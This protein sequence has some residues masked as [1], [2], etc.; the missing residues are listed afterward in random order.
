MT[1][2]PGNKFG[3]RREKPCRDALLMVL[4]EA[5]EDMPE[6]R[7]IMQQVKKLALGGERWAA[8]EIWDRLDGKVPTE[9]K[10]ELGPLESMSDEQL[11][12]TFDALNAYLSTAG[13]ET[14]QPGDAEATRH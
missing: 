1:F 3:G 14:G 10:I 13:L 11:R 9:A 5:G 8:I 6:L 4:K 2:K 12:T 7:Q